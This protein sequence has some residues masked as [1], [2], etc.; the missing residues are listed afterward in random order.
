MAVRGVRAARHRHAGLHRRPASGRCR[1]SATGAWPTSTRSA[2]PSARAG[3]S[4]TSR[5]RCSPR[6]RRCSSARRATTRPR[7]PASSPATSS[8]STSAREGDFAKYGGTLR[9]KIVVMQPVRPV[10]MLEGPVILRMDEGTVWTEA[11]NVPQIQPPR[12]PTPAE[13]AETETRQALAAATRAFLV[14]EGAAVLLERGSDGDLSAGGSDLS[15]ETQRVDGGTIFPTS[16]GSRDPN[17]PAQVPSAT[18]VGR[19]LQPSG[20]AARARP[21]GADGGEHP[22]HLPPR[23]RA[24]ATASTPSPRFPAPTWRTKW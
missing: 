23:R 5:R 7:R 12:P 22:D 10:R 20:A 6:S 19:A 16:G 1:S 21:G 15:W 2:G 9:G 3:P 11:A 8:P 13:R 17:A 24:S 14:R 18:L 4:I